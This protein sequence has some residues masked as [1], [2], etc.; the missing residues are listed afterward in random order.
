[1]LSYLVTS[2]TRRRLLELLWGRG[3]SGSAT[4]LA[5]Q[6]DLSVTG[7]YREL[8][9]MVRHGL[10]AT[11]FEDGVEKYVA[12]TE[13]PHADLLRMLVSTRQVTPHRHTEASRATRGQLRSLGAPLSIPAEPVAPAQREQVIVDGVR[14]ARH[15]PT[16][17]RVLPIV[18]WAQRTMIDPE[19]LEAAARTGRVKHAL[20]FMLALTAELARDRGLKRLA[21]SFRDH[22][23]RGT[24]PFFE[25]PSSRAADELAARRTPDVAR[26]WGFLMNMDL[27]SFE[28]QFTKHVHGDGSV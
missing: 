5:E 1:M 11:R 17:A 15:D 28:S 6:L 8:Q 26:K 10:V 16:I 7:V 20:G 27:A 23:A 19:R 2:R 25:L 22:R 4:G 18:L 14:L 12:A 9:T 3:G 13:H 24:R 21:E